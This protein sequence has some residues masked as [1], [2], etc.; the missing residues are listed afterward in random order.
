MKSGRKRWFLLALSGIAGLVAS[1]TLGWLAPGAS[2]KPPLAPSQPLGAP[3]GIKPTAAPAARPNTSPAPRA[4]A[5]PSTSGFAKM[6][7]PQPIGAGPGDWPMWGGSVIR[8]NTPQGKNIPTDWEAGEF[9]SKTGDWKKDTAQNIKWV[10]RL[11]SQSYGNPIVANGKVYVGSNNGAGYL[12]RYP[13]SVDLG[14]LLCFNEAD[15]KFLWQHSNEKLP[16]GR[17]HDW[18]LQGVCAAAFAEG[19]RVWYVTNRGEVVCLDANGFHD[20]ADN[21]PVTGELGRLFD[22]MKNEDAAKDKFAPTV[23]SLK[24]GKLTPELRANFADAGLTVPESVKIDAEKTSFKFAFS[25]PSGTE[26][27]VVLRIEGPRLSVYKVIN[28]DD[29]DEADVI[30][31]LNMMHEPLGISQHNMCACSV[32]AVGDILFVNTSNG[33]DEGHINLPA[34]HAPSFVALDKNTGAVLWTD[35]SPGSNVLHGQWSSPAYAVFDGVPQ[36]LFGAG[37]GWLYS[38]RGD[39]SNE[40]GHPLHLWKFD[41]N[42]KES[43]Y[44]LGGRANRNHIIGTPVLYKGLVYVGVGEDPE[45]G[46]GVGHLWCIDPRKSGDVSS[47]LAF[48]LP[49]LKHPIPHRR[50]QAVIKEEGEV[51]RP[52]PNSA[53][54][55]HYESYDQNGNGKIEFEETMHRTCGTVCIKDDLLFVADFSGLV[56]CVDAMTGKP[57]W[58]HDM[59]AACWSSP[60]IVDDKV[61]IGDEDGDITV[62]KLS[63]KKEVLSEHNMGSAVYSTPIVANGI[64]FISDKDHLFAIE[65][66]DK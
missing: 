46:E 4:A 48:K 63:A 13:A 38:F 66:S 56:H 30:W 31:K 55:W 47:E 54:V 17:V 9:D 7:Y 25:G 37:D 64:L 36:V 18:P 62:F 24:Q 49:D 61:Y 59:L 50:I 53:A 39:A 26:R 43:K 12:K 60:L 44:V 45:H 23:A 65:A 5:K 8:N 28:V 16:T 27:Q 58:T 35:S 42:P 3:G 40:G 10:S 57:H 11:G 1:Q 14:V 34:P 15:G 21:G 6:E 33:V 2:A 52:N 22:I 29:K 51:A 41:C 20:G 19:D 32:A